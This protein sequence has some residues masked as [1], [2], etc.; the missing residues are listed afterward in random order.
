MASA[1]S[2]SIDVATVAVLHS[3]NLVYLSDVLSYPEPSLHSKNKVF[4]H[5]V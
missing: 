5:A 1:F 2:V 3:M 4:G